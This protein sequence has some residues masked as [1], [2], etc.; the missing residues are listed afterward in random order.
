MQIESY[1]LFLNVDFRN[2]RFD[3]KVKIKLESETD[4]K[5][6]SVELE[7]LEVDA[8]GKPV[9]YNLEGEDFTIKTGKFVGELGIR[10][11]GSISDKLVGLYKA[12]YEGGYVVS[13]QFEAVSARRL[14][15]CMD[16]PAYKADFKLTIRTDS[17]TSVISNMPSTSVRVDGPRKTVEFPKT[18][19]MST[20]LMYLGIGK[21]EEVKDRFNGVDYIV[22]T[23]PGK[24]SGAKFPLDVAKDSVRFFESYFGSKYN[25]PKL[26]LIGVPEFAAGAMENWGAITFREIALLVDDDSSIRI[27]KQVAEVIAHEVSHQWFGDLVTMK[28]WDDL[29]LNES[30]ATF[31][32]Y[33]A[34][35]SMFPRWVVWQDFVRGE[36]AGALARDSLVN[37]HPIEVRVNSPTEIEEIFDDISY[38]KGASI[39]RM[40]EAYAGEDEFMHGVRSYL[41]KYKFSNAAG[42]DLWNE[43]ERTSKTR[44]KAIMNDWIRKPGYP[45]V[46]VK[47]DGKKLMIR[48]HRF[49][50]N[51][52]AEPSS[53]P[54]PI[55][56]KINGK[57]QKL[58]M[59]KSEE[60]IAVPDGVDSLKLN[61]EE[62]GFYRVYYE[63]LYDKVWRSNMSPVDRYGIVSDAYAFAIQG[64]MDFSQYLAL[65]NR[66]MNEQEYLPAFEVSDQL[67]SLSTITRSVEETSRKFH[68]NQLKILANR[69]DENSVAL[70]GSV[71]S[72]LALLDMEYAKE[73]SLRFNDYETAEP[74]M[75][76]AIVVAH[77]RA[78]GDFESLFKNYKNRP[79]EEE[80]SRFLIGLTSF[81]QPSLNSRAMDLASSGEIKKQHVGTLLGSAARN[82]DARDGTWDWIAQKF[83]W[84]R[85]I[86]E[87]T[88]VLSRYLTYVLPILGIDR[89]EE[90]TKFFAKHKAPEIIKGVEAGL[91]KLRIN[92]AF[93]RRIGPSQKQMVEVQERR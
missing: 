40:L 38:G 66:Y 24:S 89:T 8:N 13:T 55:T 28:W 32:A 44:V 58:L 26:H 19:R 42:N 33:K 23:V 79:S 76:Q 18:P 90:V 39:I 63:G 73:L 37:T 72:R 27:R 45:V 51:G 67:S 74:D 25:L 5:L 10:Y 34:L 69:K 21:F 85:G 59:E 22:A 57:E 60:S 92:E 56:L 84:L 93:L 31:M 65:I 62:T 3:G 91:E 2:L 83:E 70:Q 17:D 16:H 11:R 78:S 35:D 14:L 88:G 46:N 68:R 71:A 81:N 1:D 9:K 7:I 50:L 77:A 87:G 64:K 43:I 36:T 48:Q 4:V 80:K 52:S 82:P 41:E 30:F 61:L 20:Y 86:Y 12:A 53:W 54:V 6:N 29:W 75:K 15:P 49:L 47:L